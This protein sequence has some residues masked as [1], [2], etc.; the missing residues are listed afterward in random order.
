MD[1][2]DH[3]TVASNC[4]LS[5]IALF[6][7]Q[8]QQ[9]DIIEGQWEK[10]NPTNSLEGSNVIEFIVRGNDSVIDLH[11]CYIQTKI[12]IVKDD[13]TNVPAAKVVGILNYPGATLFQQVDVFLNNTQVLTS[14]H[15]AYK[16]YL[17]TLLTYSAAAKKTWLQGA[18]FFKDTSTGMDTMTDAN[19]GF[20]DR[21]AFLKESKSVELFSKIHCDLFNQERMLVNGVDLKLVMTRNTD[22]FC[23]MTTDADDYKIEI[24]EA[25]LMVR[26]NKLADHKFIEM[27]SNIAKQDAKYFIPHVEIKAFT[28]SAAAQNISLTNFITGRDLPKRIVVGMIPNKAYHGSKTLNPF[29]FKNYRLTSA[30]ITVN[31]K[32][33]F[34]K[35]LSLNF[36]T[37]QTMQAY[38][39]M[40]NSLGYQFRDDGCNIARNEYTNGYTL[41]CADLTSTL[42]NGQYADPTLTGNME[43]QLAFSAA[44]PETISII[45]YTEFDRTI[46]INSARKALVNF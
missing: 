33:V 32:S 17:E 44:L 24:E 43:I 4:S 6:E 28:F 46:S 18:L 11:N 2:T 31:N 29:N 1:F 3:H 8:F 26:R 42:C 15:Y 16:S 21:R 27:Q 39:A 22:Q 30:D 45:V 19:V 37:G 20:K 25:F 12:K 35:P 41:I 13:G 23:L 7:G 9:E 10:V 5:S 38:W 36:T 40:Y 14:P 34:G